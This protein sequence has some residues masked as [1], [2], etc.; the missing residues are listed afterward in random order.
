MRSQLNTSLRFVLSLNPLTFSD[1]IVKAIDILLVFFF[2]CRIPVVLENRRS[3]HGEEGG[4]GA[5]PLH[6]PPRSAPELD[7]EGRKIILENGG[8][9]PKESKAIL[10][11]SRKLGGGGLNSLENEHKN[12]KIKAAVKLY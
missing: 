4:G 9:H 1:A 8:N 10:Y 12:T 11:M 3:S 5:Q 7:R 6:S 2:F